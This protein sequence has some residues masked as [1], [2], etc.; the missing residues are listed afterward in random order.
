M[1]FEKEVRTLITSSGQSED[2]GQTQNLEVSQRAN[3]IM[4]SIVVLHAM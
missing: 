4:D 2:V 3:L 1:E